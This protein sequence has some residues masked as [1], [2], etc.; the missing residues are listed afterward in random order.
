MVNYYRNIW[1]GRSHHLAP[2]TQIVGKK[3]KFQWKEPQQRAFD[4]L[5]TI[6]SEETMLLFPN[7]Q[8]EFII[9]TDVSDYQLGGAISQ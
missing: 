5:K 8:Q 3:S 6:I 9:H 7:F 2:L 4:Q 1:R